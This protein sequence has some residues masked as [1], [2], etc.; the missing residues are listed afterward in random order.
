MIT[1]AFRTLPVRASSSAPKTLLQRRKSCELAKRFVVSGTQAC[2]QKG[3][4]LMD[5]Y[6]CVHAW[7]AEE[8]R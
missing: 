1:S 2:Q 8:K 5:I 3:G 4:S 6:T 7:R